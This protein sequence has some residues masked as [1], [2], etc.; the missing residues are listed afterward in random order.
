M[1]P[2]VNL[3]HHGINIGDDIQSIAQQRFLSPPYDVINREHMH[4]FSKKVRVIMSAWFLGLHRNWPP[5]KEITPIFISFHIANEYLASKK[6]ADYYKKYEPIGCRDLNTMKLLQNIGVKAYFSGCLTLTLIRP[7]LPRTEKIYVVDAHLTEK[8]KYPFGANNLFKALIP[9]DIKLKAEY[10]EH[11]TP[12]GLLKKNRQKYA[13]SLLEKYATAKLVITSRLHC[14]LPCLA[15]GTPV[16]FLENRL[17]TCKRYSGYHEYFHGYHKEDQKIDIDWDTLTLAPR[18]DI[19][20][21]IN[22]LLKD[23]EDRLSK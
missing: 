7:N 14:L 1:I 9:D 10:I 23:I 11:N 15:Y 16:I 5:N 19:Q 4:T 8:V 20:P 22:N 12:P 17:H 3:I 21:L 6:F 18:K 2:L 13:S